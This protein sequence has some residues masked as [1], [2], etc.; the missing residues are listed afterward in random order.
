MHRIKHQLN[1][2]ITVRIISC[3][4]V[5]SFDAAPFTSDATDRIPRLL[6]SV[7]LAN[8][9]AA[10]RTGCQTGPSKPFLKT[11]CKPVDFG[12]LA[13]FVCCFPKPLVFGMA[14]VH[15]GLASE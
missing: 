15:W 13:R 12:A 2:G 5:R 6:S 11:V 3:I 8:G 10:S 4:T 7:P 14:H 1:V 9:G